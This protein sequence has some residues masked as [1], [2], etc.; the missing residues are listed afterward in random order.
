VL[1]EPNEVID[2]TVWSD[3]VA[4][5]GLSGANKNTTGSAY[6]IGVLVR[7]EFRPTAADLWLRPPVVLLAFLTHW[8]QAG[9][10]EASGL[11]DTDG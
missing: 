3:A 2:Q 7:D 8:H 6:G 4:F 9:L 1:P 11:R 5:L 10:A